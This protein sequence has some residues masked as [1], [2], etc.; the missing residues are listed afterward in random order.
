MTQLNA[1]LDATMKKLEN[2]K[3]RQ[4]DKHNLK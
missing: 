3:K 2:E 4:N 1:D